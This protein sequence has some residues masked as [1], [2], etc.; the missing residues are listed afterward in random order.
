MPFSPAFFS[1]EEDAVSKLFTGISKAA[2]AMQTVAQSNKTSSNTDGEKTIQTLQK[3]LT[4]VL[5]LTTSSA[6]ESSSGNTAA[7]TA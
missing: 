3:E 6:P 5:R 7:P 1:T 2:T 4:E